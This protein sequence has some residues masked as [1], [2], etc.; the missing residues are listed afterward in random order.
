MGPDRKTACLR[1]IPIA[2]FTPNAIFSYWGTIGRLGELINVRKPHK[3]TISCNGTFNVG[4]F[5]YTPL[6]MLTDEE[7]QSL[8][9]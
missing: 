4:F 9:Y 7:A 6:H 8:N 3:V 1:K 2:R 5:L